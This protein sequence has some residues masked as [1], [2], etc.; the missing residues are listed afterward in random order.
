MVE[1]AESSSGTSSVAFNI[2]Q[3]RFILLA[4][5][6]SLRPRCPLLLSPYSLFPYAS[7][8]RLVRR[9]ACRLAVRLV[10]CVSAA[11]SCHLAVLP[12]CPARRSACRLVLLVVSFGAV[13]FC[14][15]LIRFVCRGVLPC[16]LMPFRFVLA[17]RRSVSL[18][19]S[20]CSSRFCHVISFSLAR[21]LFVFVFSFLFPCSRR[22]MLLA[23][24]SLPFMPHRSSHLIGLFSS[25]PLVAFP[26]P[27]PQ[28]KQEEA[29]GDGESETG[30]RQ[31][32]RYDETTRQ[33][34]QRD[35][36]EKRGRHEN[37]QATRRRNET[38]YTRRRTRRPL[39]KSERQTTTVMGSCRFF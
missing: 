19:V 5:H 9:L 39:T 10:S 7:P 8:V 18:A 13:S 17:S 24:H 32:R 37:K 11:S 34:A 38:R 6:F 1:K 31:T 12:V 25:R 15:S 35:E 36:N 4:A 28:S 29:D 20:S 27:R 21:G 22:S 3:H 2:W 23:A 14:C 26:S 16:G 30:T 33:D